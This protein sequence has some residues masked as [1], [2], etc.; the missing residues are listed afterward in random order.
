MVLDRDPLLEL[1]MSGHGDHAHPAGAEH[2][3]DAELTGHDRS[4]L[5]HV[6]GYHRVMRGLWISF[7][8]AACS[9]SATAPS[10]PAATAPSNCERVSDHLVSLMGAS[11]AATDDQLDPFRRVIATRCEQD[12]WTAAA[13]QCFLETKSLADGDRCQSQLTPSQQQALQRDGMATV[14]SAHAAEPAAQP[15]PA[16]APKK[17]G[18]PCEGGE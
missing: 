9:H 4:D 11:S 10:A 17:T 8:L 2:P 16:P 15:A 3:L 13:Q 18:D 6:S 12:V 5:E 7:V 14:N 1:D